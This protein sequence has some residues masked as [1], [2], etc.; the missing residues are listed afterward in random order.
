MWELQNLEYFEIINPNEMFLCL[1]PIHI[2][3]R[4]EDVIREE[5]ENFI[6]ALEENLILDEYRQDAITFTIQA[7]QRIIDVL[8]LLRTQGIEI[9]VVLDAKGSA[10]GI[11][12]ISDIEKHIADEVL[13]AA[14]R[15]KK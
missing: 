5:I 4:N 8:E 7:E 14:K 2:F 9:A 15:K 11:I 10:L 1:I 6:I 12:R 13:L 3:K